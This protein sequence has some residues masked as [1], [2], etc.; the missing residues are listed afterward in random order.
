MDKA[1]EALYN[2]SPVW[3]Q[4][5][6]VTAYGYRL[7]RKRYTGDFQKILELVRES[8][9]WTKSEIEA[10]QNEKLHLMVKHCRHNVPYYQKLFADFGLHENDVTSISD[11]TRIPTLSKQTLR[12]RINEF[13]DPGTPSYMTQHTSGSTG[14]PLKLEVNEYTYKLAMALLV[15]HEEH[16][17]VPFG[18]RRAT[19]AGRM[20]Q[21]STKMSPPFARMN[22]AEN[23]KLFSAY[24]LN[25]KTFPWYRRE[26]DTYQP[27]ELIGY[28]SALCDLANHYQESGERPSFIPKTIITNSETVLEWQ[29]EL[30]EKVFQCE[31]KDYYGTAEYL[32]FAGQEGKEYRVNPI[33][34]IAELAQFN[35]E[36]FSGELVTTTLEN[37][38]MP[39]L[40]YSIGDTA[41]ISL[42]ARQNA[43]LKIDFFSRVA[44]RT[45]DYIISHDGRRIGRIDHIFKGLQDIKEAQVI[46]R[47]ECCI[48]KVVPKENANRDLITKSILEKF[49]SRTGGHLKVSV[50]FENEIARG[51]NGKFKAV[52]V[53]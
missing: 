3:L 46:Q 2:L 30:I 47:K 20:I 19:F 43:P 18:A 12:S 24:H 42:D 29:R 48:I 27:E 26:L 1:A 28:P 4:N 37:R 33:I 11:L 31:I 38:C 49:H 45:D 40:R 51:P 53:E 16:H 15:D 52:L 5:L 14:T 34:G 13:R 7:Y 23:Q 8:R 21:P 39:L 50:H 35:C 6:L 41:Q 17:G 25:K 44:G 9:T 10:Y 22:L 32:I 36:T